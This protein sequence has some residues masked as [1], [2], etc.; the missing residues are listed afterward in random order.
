MWILLSPEGGRAALS[1]K[2]NQGPKHDAAE[3]IGVV[4]GPTGNTIPHHV[5]TTLTDVITSNTTTAV[6]N[7]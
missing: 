3:Q 1:T 6:H 5:A 7:F 4:R 2:G